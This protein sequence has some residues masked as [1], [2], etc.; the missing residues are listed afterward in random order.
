[1]LK[2]AIHIHSTYSDGEY[3][4]AEL[5]AVLH[6][7]GCRFACMT[8]HAEWFDRQKLEAYVAECAALSDDHF[9]FIAGLEYKCERKMHVL[10]L[11]VTS[12]AQTENPQEVI[13]HIEREGGVSVIAHP[14]NSMFPWI[15]SF[16]ALPFGIETWNSKY[17]GQHAP[18][19]GTFNLLNRLQDRRPEMRAFYG[20]DLHWKRQPRVLFMMIEGASFR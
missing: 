20:Q 4:L 6:G 1:M 14:M 18:R 8:D 7:L 5:R 19:P 2:G 16:D 13:G 10:G 11:G 3:T 9:Q 15:E 17:D 12:L